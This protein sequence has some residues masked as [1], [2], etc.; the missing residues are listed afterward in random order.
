MAN[1]V[2]AGVTDDERRTLEACPRIRM[3]TLPGASYFTPNEE[4]ALVAK[5]VI[6]ALDQVRSDQEEQRS[7]HRE[8][9]QD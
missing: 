1:A 9:G 8:G 7:E 3:I 4:P 5:L 6:E 2:T